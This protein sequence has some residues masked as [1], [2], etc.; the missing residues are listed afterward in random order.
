MLHLGAAREWDPPVL[1]TTASREKDW[2]SLWEAIEDHRTH[3]EASGALYEKRRA[4]LIR[5]V[6]GLAAERFRLRQSS[7]LRDA[8][9]LLHDLEGRRVDPYRAAAMLAEGADPVAG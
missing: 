4:R 2:S 9:Q 3:V 7:R 6:E 1:T 5:E 8:P